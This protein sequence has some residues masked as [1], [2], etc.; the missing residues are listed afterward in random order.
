MEW[1]YYFKSDLPRGLVYWAD[2]LEEFAHKALSRR[3]TQAT[4]EILSSLAAIGMSYADARRNS[5][6]LEPD[7]RNFFVTNSDV[8]DVLNPIYEIVRRVYEAAIRQSN[9]QV[10][11]GCV[12]AIST[13]A[14]FFMEVVCCQSDHLPSA[15]LVAAP[16][17]YIGLFSDAAAA[18]G[19]DDVLLR[20][21]QRTDAILA[22]SSKAVATHEVGVA[23]IKNMSNI[24]RNSQMSSKVVPCMAAAETLM[25][26]AGRDI[27]LHGYYPASLF[28]SVVKALPQMVGLE[29]VQ[30]LRG[31]RQVKTFPP[32]DIAFASNVPSLLREIAKQIGPQD[33]T[34]AFLSPFGDYAAVSEAIIDHYRTVGHIV[35]FKNA[36]LEKWVLDSI[37]RIADIHLYV[38]TLE[39]HKDSRFLREIIDELRSTISVFSCFFRDKEAFPSRHAKDVAGGLAIVAMKLLVHGQID[40]AHECGTAIAHIGKKCIESSEPRP[41]AIADI[42]ENIEQISRAADALGHSSL[43]QQ[44][45]DL[46]NSPPMPA[47][48][49]PEYRD[50]L[51]TRLHQL[52]EELEGY[53]YQP[54]L[55]DD[56]TPILRQ[57]LVDCRAATN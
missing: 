4:L 24:I 46:T 29:V 32:Y 2:Q 52:D 45:R 7:S 27:Y 39:G 11:I 36:L 56:P 12:G 44:L 54:A 15:P 31:N 25:R 35:P 53:R 51:A 20:V 18:A 8:S 22:K 17:F 23:A 5:I 14:E 47:A 30:E 16:M 42:F 57:I 13:M 33:P 19:M 38:L 50:A 9:E 48:D 3:D 41:Y 40:V 10:A 21:A 43:G 37:L 34:R 28:S 49:L 6:I 26:I 55:P 1:A